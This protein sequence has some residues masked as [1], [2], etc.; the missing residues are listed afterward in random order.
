[1]YTTVKKFGVFFMFLNKVSNVHQVC[2]YLIQKNSNIVKYY[3]NFNSVF[4]FQLFSIVIYCKMYFISVI[5]FQ[6]S[7]M[8]RKLKK[9]NNIWN[10]NLL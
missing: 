6:D 1:M 9:K 4:C 8:N 2:I 3:Y 5:F 10:W 7:L